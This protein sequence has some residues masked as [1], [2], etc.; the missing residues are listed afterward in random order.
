MDTK[1]SVLFTWHAI[2]SGPALPTSLGIKSALSN[3]FDNETSLPF[4]PPKSC[5][6]CKKTSYIYITDSR[7]FI[8]K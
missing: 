5:F 7:V 1:Q 3:N 4:F 2:S 6:V 8:K